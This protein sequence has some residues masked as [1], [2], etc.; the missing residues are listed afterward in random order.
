MIGDWDKKFIE[1]TNRHV[2]IIEVITG[3]VVWVADLFSEEQHHHL[4]HKDLQ[5]A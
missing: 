3:Q 5:S 4:H 2:D 1:T